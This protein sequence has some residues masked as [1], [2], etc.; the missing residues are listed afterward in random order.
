MLETQYQDLLTGFSKRTTHTDKANWRRQQKIMIEL[1]EELQPYE[2]AI[3]E[4]QAEKSKIV[5]QIAD[6]RQK[7]VHKCIHPIDHL[8]IKD[9]SPDTHIIVECKFCDKQLTIRKS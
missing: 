9:D 7:M 2:Q 6:L 5:D 4:A 3:L 8:V 1:I